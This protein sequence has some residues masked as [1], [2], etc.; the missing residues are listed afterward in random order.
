[1]K[2]INFFLIAIILA[3]ALAWLPA[4]QSTD[5]TGPT[6][7]DILTREQ[8]PNLD[9]PYGGYNLADEAPG[10]EDAAL[11]D[12]FGE[13]ATREYD[14][15]MNRDP[16]VADIL[17]R[18]AAQHFLMITWGNLERDSTIDFVTEWS[19]S[20]T[21][22]PGIILLKRLIRFENHDRILP[23]ERR[24]LLEW[25]SFTQ[26][27][28]DGII[29][30]ILPAPRLTAADIKDTTTVVTFSTGP[31][32]K[33][34]TIAELRDI[35]EVIPVD[36]AGNAVA[37]NSIVI[38]AGGCP[39]G[40]L[41]GIWADN[42]DTTGGHFRGMWMSEKGHAMGFLKGHYGVNSEGNRVFF[43]KWIGLT[44]EFKGLIKG[45]Y[46]SF[47]NAPG[48]FFQGVYLD[49]SLRIRGDLKGIWKTSAAVTG[50]GFFKGQ[51]AARCPNIVRP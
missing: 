40:F 49:R 7:N 21:V 38:P 39:S 18:P 1:M 35:H 16:L 42:P 19:G 26:P 46:G 34:F 33:S 28:F 51:W 17:S 22:D 9:D 11:I 32:T 29:V 43:G 31:L 6:E 12:E 45:R 10:F 47:P 41:G 37:F 4:C 36:R 20:L 48:G 14:D 30:R 2:R 27:A 15:P 3:G 24:D 44:G 25:I 5:V 23:R 8:D 50:G 13:D